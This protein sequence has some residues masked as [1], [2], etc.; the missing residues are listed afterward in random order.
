MTLFNSGLEVPVGWGQYKHPNDDIYYYHPD[1]RLITPEDI[2]DPVMLQFV[3][4]ARL[5]HLQCLQ[6]DDSLSKLADDWELT[7]TDVTDA[8]A[9]IG[10]FSRNLGVAYEWSE[11]KGTNLKNS[12]CAFIPT[13]CFPAGL[14]L[15]TPEYFWS[16]VAEYP[17]HHAELP[18]NAESEFRK[19]LTN[20][21][22]FRPCVF[23]KCHRQAALIAARTSVDQGVVFPFSKEQ[24]EHISNQYHHLKGLFNFVSSWTNHKMVDVHRTPSPRQECYTEYWLA[25]WR[26]HA[27]RK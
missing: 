5:D 15:K 18:P 16:H 6:A 9:V 26:H 20:G 3:L 13:V 4:D 8:A 23:M 25:Y 2:R 24:I 10:M 19:A 27:T 14:E 1:L 7:L 11:G 17:S 22:S 21:G 12:L